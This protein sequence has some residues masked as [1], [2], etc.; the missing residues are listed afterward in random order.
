[1][2]TSNPSTSN[3]SQYRPNQTITSSCRYASARTISFFLGPDSSIDTTN[4]TTTGTNGSNNDHPAFSSGTIIITNAMGSIKP[5]AIPA[6][7]PD[8]TDDSSESR[9]RMLLIDLWYP[10]RPISPGRIGM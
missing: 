8:Q 2:L 10:M 3:A 1:M 5:L 9:R 6:R 7:I 4:A